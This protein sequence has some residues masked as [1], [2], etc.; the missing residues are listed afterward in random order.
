MSD[1]KIVGVGICQYCKMECNPASQACGYCMREVNMRSL[2]MK[3]DLPPWI[4]DGRFNRDSATWRKIRII[5]F[6]PNL[7]HEKKTKE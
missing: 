2:G 6:N 4:E 3:R 1:K 7:N 5:D